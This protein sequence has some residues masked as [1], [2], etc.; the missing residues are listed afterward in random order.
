MNEMDEIDQE[1]VR[2]MLGEHLEDAPDGIPMDESSES[3][4]EDKLEGEIDLILAKITKRVVKAS[5]THLYRE[6]LKFDV[7]YHPDNIFD[8]NVDRCIDVGREALPVIAGN[9]E[10]NSMVDHSHAGSVIDDANIFNQA[11]EDEYANQ[12]LSI[13]DESSDGRKSLDDYLESAGNSCSDVS[14]SYW[15]EHNAE[16]HCKL[17]PLAANQIII[18][19][20]TKGLGNFGL[21]GGAFADASQNIHQQ[22]A[23]SSEPKRPFQEGNI[24]DAAKP[25]TAKRA[26]VAPKSRRQIADKNWE[27]HFNEY[28]AYVKANKTRRVP[29]REKVAGTGGHG[30]NKSLAA[31]F[32]KQGNMFRQGNYKFM[33]EERFERLSEV[34]FDWGRQKDVFESTYLVLLDFFYIV[35]HSDFP[36][37]PLNKSSGAEKLAAK[38]DKVLRGKVIDK[39]QRKQVEELL[40]QPQMPRRITM[41][42]DEYKEWED[43]HLTNGS[44]PMEKKLDDMYCLW[45]IREAK[46]EKI[47][48]RFS[49]QTRRAKQG[50][51]RMNGK[52]K[53][54]FC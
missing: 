26:R 6:S 41:L 38:A 46:L 30:W 19:C 54:R 25:A 50:L 5:V 44:S 35:D 15:T 27:F 4:T 13:V 14:S 22:A 43:W 2:T 10:H 32:M 18:P 52:S 47:K 33:T 21:A 29:Q 31:W 16:E 9:T 34:D 11:D 24:F 39:A 49:C 1:F 7:G 17:P 8:G 48:F 3:E 36:T 28:V 20:A 23:P 51:K 12:F 53:S 37:T 42:R 40:K 45:K